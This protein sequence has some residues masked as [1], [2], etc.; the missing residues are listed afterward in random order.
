MQF[1]CD[2]CVQGAKKATGCVVGVQQIVRVVCCSP[3]CVFGVS[4]HRLLL[5]VT[6][7]RLDSRMCMS[8]SCH[9]LF[10]HA[11]TRT[12]KCHVLA[13]PLFMSDTFPTSR[14]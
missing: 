3:P 7:F 10:L 5:L 6:L 14:S 2:M 9:L 12:R 8:H 13:S 11:C 1:S 4:R